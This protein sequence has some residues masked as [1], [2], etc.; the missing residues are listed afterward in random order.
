MSGLDRNKGRAI[1]G[2][3]HL[4]QSITDI[5]TTPIGSRVMRRDYGSELPNLIDHPINGETVVDVMIAT[6]E[7]LDLWEPRITVERVEVA[8]A[9]PGRLELRLLDT[10][11]ETIPLL[12]GE[13]A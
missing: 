5:L 6:A 13:A 9:G 7:A 11:G 12:L 8:D 3:A 2:N 4:A 1:A 10:E